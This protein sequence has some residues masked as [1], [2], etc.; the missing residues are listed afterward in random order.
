MKLNSHSLQIRKKHNNIFYRPAIKHCFRSS[1]IL[2]N[3]LFSNK[4]NKN[5]YNKNNIGGRKFYYFATSQHHDGVLMTMKYSSWF[6]IPALLQES[7][8]L[9]LY[10]YVPMGYRHFCGN[11]VFEYREKYNGFISN[12]VCELWRFV[13]VLLWYTQKY[14]KTYPGW[15]IISPGY[16]N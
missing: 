1:V 3:R 8:R 11:F 9:F 15:K 10:A 2:S 16:S 5:K 7:C 13:Y 12:A 6:I 4:Q 14:R